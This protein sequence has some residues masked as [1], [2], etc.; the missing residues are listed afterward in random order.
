MAT[1]L[2]TFPRRDGKCLAGISSFGMS[3]TNSHLILEEAPEGNS[4][5][6]G[7]AANKERICA[8]RGQFTRAFG[9]LIAVVG[10]L[11]P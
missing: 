6:G 7:D 11:V 4:N 9:P 10:Q 5:S 2:Q 8:V 3:G 1:S